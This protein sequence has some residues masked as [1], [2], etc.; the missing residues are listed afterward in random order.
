MFYHYTTGMHLPLILE[1]GCLNTSPSPDRLL[2]RE[3]AGVWF[4]SEDCVFPGSACKIIQ[5]HGH[6]TRLGQTGMVELF[7]LYR[8]RFRKCAQERGLKHGPQIA[9]W[10][11][12]P[13]SLYRVLVSSA[14]DTGEDPRKWALS[15]VPVPLSMCGVERYVDGA[16]RTQFDQS[17]DKLQFKI[18]S[19]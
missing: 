10:M 19:Y 17:T 16:W 12:I 18:E 2:P 5:V 7:D 3:R 1:S 13:D 4:T 14:K 11:R 9:K 6:Q 8:F 15:T